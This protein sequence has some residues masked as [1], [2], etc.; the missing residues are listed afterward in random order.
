[1]VKQNAT[2]C[3]PS[4]DYLILTS[5]PVSCLTVDWVHLV[6]FHLYIPDLSAC[7]C[8]SFSFFCSFPFYPLSSF[9]PPFYSALPGLFPL[10]FSACANLLFPE[11]F[12]Y[13]TS[14]RAPGEGSS[15]SVSFLL[16]AGFLLSHWLVE[17]L[18]IFPRTCI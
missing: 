7:V 5:C 18:V 9:F 1:M 11:N 16:S 3:I 8:C 6:I 15:P 2:M 12:S 10:I 17:S 14:H 13:L 4:I